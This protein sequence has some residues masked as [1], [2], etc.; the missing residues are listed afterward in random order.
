[1]NNEFETEN[2][3]DLLKIS[4]KASIKSAVVYGKEYYYIDNY[5]LYAPTGIYVSKETGKIIRE[6]PFIGY[7]GSNV[8]ISEKIY[9]FDTVTEEDLKEP[10][11]SEYEVLNGNE[12][13]QM[14]LMRGEI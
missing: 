5:G 13:K 10:D 6:D 3:L 4:L 8:E 7:E 11:I 14:Q 2:L 1:M 9:E 12:E